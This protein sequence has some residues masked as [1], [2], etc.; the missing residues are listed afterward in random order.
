MNISKKFL[1][2]SIA[3]SFLLIAAG[4]T[5]FSDYQ[6]NNSVNK[7][8]FKIQLADNNKNL[9]REILGKDGQ[10]ISLINKFEVGDSL[11]FETKPNSKN[12]YLHLK[13][14]IKTLVKN[15][16]KKSKGY[17]DFLGTNIKTYIKEEC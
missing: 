14:K 11:D 9:H 16:P 17:F 13:P 10:T 7:Y 3:S 1:V 8:N 6:S 15:K 12:G 4:I 5:V 2:F